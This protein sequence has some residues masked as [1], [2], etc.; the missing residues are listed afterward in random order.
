M[1]RFFLTP[2]HITPDHVVF[3]P[4]P[5]RQ[6]RVVLR[7][8]AGATVAVL[9]NSGMMYEVKLAH[10][11]RDGVIGDIVSKQPTLGEPA[12]QITLFQSFLK[13]DKFETV[14]QKCT[15]LGVSR[16]APVV[17]KRTLVQSTE[18]K[19]NKTSRWQ[20][21]LQEAAEQSER[22]R[23]PKLAEPLTF[24]AMLAQLADFD[25]A[26]MLYAGEGGVGL[27][28]AVSQTQPKTIALLIGPEGGYTDQEVTQAR[29]AGAH[30]I[31]LGPRILRTETA[32]IVATALTL[33]ELEPI[34]N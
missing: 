7:M 14:L 3:P 23:I 33:H 13:R 15:E 10:V 17:T 9:D 34:H 31:T 25:L 11:D 12:V 19:A 26:L 27:K 1:H 8:E 4:A 5:A 18:M 28:T 29:A 2:A 6:I 22:G 24:K 16:F 21:I 20:A 30:I 32:A